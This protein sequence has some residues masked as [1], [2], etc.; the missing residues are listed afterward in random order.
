LP[1]GGKKEMMPMLNS[2]NF[3]IIKDEET[4]SLMPQFNHLYKRRAR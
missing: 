2:G 4:G 1:W 3:F